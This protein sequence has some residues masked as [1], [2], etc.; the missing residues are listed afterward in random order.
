MS[1]RKYLQAGVDIE[2]FDLFE[3]MLKTLR[4]K[5]AALGLSPRLHQADMCDFSLPRRFGL[6]MIPFNAF[7]HNMTQESQIR[8]L[9][10][11][12]EHLLP[13]G[14]LAFEL[15]ASLPFADLNGDLFLGWHQCLA[16][17]FQAS[18]SGPSRVRFGGRWLPTTLVT[19]I[20]CVAKIPSLLSRHSTDADES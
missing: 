4:A 14:T 12:R 9:R 20:C 2:K 3:P 16:V 1:S 10:L 8:C 11:C 19:T 15:S 5:A 13:G 7:I 6:V 18:Q 17:D